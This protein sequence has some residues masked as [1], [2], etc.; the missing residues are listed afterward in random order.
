MGFRITVADSASSSPQEIEKL[1][2]GLY[3]DIFS[4]SAIHE[5]LTESALYPHW[6]DFGTRSQISLLCFG[7]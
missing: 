5:T 4:T 3:K 6:M 7:R 1:T 2:N